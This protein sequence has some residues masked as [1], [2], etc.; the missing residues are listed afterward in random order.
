MF[1]P[2]LETAGSAGAAGGRRRAGG[3]LQKMKKSG[4]PALPCGGWWLTGEDGA[5]AA[6]GDKQ[7]REM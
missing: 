6:C 2:P 1:G 7:L 4:A 3:Q 5:A